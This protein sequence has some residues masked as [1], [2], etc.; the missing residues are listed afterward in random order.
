MKD[1]FK[2]TLA[3][4]TSAVGCASSS[5]A[6]APTSKF[7]GTW[8][9]AADSTIVAD[10]PGAPSQTIDLSKVPPSNRP[11]YF[12]ISDAEAAHLHEIDARGCAYDWSVSG[13]SATAAG[14]SC[15]T[16]PDGRGGN[17]VVHMQSGTKTTHDGA[18]MSVEIHFTTDAPSSCSIHVQG[19]ATKS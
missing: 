2:T 9:Y 6:P 19:T 5:S 7:A 10:C 18:T 1:G 3:I 11:G 17:R 8:T 12:V 15:A 4:F 16:F 14:Q 13:D